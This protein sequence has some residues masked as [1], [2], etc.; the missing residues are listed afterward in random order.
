MPGRD[1]ESRRKPIPVGT[2]PSSGV[3]R[4]QCLRRAVDRDVPSVREDSLGTGVSE[5]HTDDDDGI[6]MLVLPRR[7]RC[8]ITG[9]KGSSPDPPRTCR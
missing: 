9:G 7:P 4:P 3:V 2:A 6:R 5:G 1:S 8:R